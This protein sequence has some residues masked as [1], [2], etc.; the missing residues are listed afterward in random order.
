MPVIC[1]K[2]F[3]LLKGLLLFPQKGFEHVVSY[4]LEK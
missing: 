4:F 3:V 2:S 1:Q